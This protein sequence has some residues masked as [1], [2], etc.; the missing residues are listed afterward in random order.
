M[1][2][3][4]REGSALLE[5]PERAAR[6]WCEQW[7]DRSSAPAWA[8]GA[9]IAL[10]L[11]L[12][13]AVAGFLSGDLPRMLRGESEAYEPS[14]YRFSVV[15]ALLSGYLPAAYVWTVRGSRRAFA[16]LRPL[17]RGTQ[18][19]LDALGAGIGRFDRRQ[20]RRAGWIGIAIAIALPIAVD[21][22]PAVY[23][24]REVNPAVVG[25]RVLV[26]LLCWML[27][28]ITVAWTTDTRR[29]VAISRDRLEVDLLDLAPLAP[30]THY[31]LRNALISLGSMSIL[32]LMAADWASRPGLPWVLGAL[33]GLAITLGALGLLMPVRGAHGV[34]QAAK[35]RELAWCRR[36]IRRRREAL[37]TG[38]TGAG[39]GRLDE[40][41]AY[42]GL[43]SDV[44]A[45]PFDTST[46]LRFALYLAIPL[47]SWMG[48]ALVE[49]WLDRILG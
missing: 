8:I 46:L 19:D 28:R 18:E 21:Q 22:T 5:A 9:G 3:A 34:I 39:Q 15:F 6:P 25:H 4:L 23:A 32:S 40:L 16:G 14:E 36:E 44:R 24:F 45:W 33:M 43:V 11:L 13:M 17:L 30:L 31:G 12:V 35:A 7:M 37:D 48:G 41:V 49:R 2:Q 29:L 26:P 47:G 27:A 38:E 10:T 1:A 42:H 20:L